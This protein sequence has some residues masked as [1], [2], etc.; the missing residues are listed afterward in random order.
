MS[1]IESDHIVIISSKDEQEFEN[2][3]DAMEEIPEEEKFLSTLEDEEV[4][5]P[6]EETEE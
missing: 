6:V 1:Y 5:L 3:D 4:T 2:L